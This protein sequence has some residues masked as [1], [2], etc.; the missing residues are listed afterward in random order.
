MPRSRD[1]RKGRVSEPGRAYILTTVTAR[2]A[3]LFANF[4]SGREIARAIAWHDRAGWSRTLAWVVMP[5][6]VHWLL[7]LDQRGSLD[8]LMR[9]FK[10]Y[11]AR[12]L[13]VRLQRKGIPLWQPGFH[14]HAVRGDEDLRRLARYIVTNPLRARLVEDIGQY[15]LWDAIWLE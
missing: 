6:H 1:L 7:I 15:H 11:T 12:A 14:D 2:R 8:Q 3:H 13:N 9:S 10:G 5:D 4:L